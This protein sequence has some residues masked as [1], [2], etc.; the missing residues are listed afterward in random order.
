MDSFYTS[1]DNMNHLSDSSY[2]SV[3]PAD[4]ASLSPE[5]MAR[6]CAMIKPTNTGVAYLGHQYGASIPRYTDEYASSMSSGRATVS[7]EQL[8]YDYTPSP[9]EEPLFSQQAWQ[10]TVPVP[11]SHHGASQVASNAPVAHGPW[12]TSMNHTSNGLAPHVSPMSSGRTTI[13]PKELALDYT[14]EPDEKSLFPKQQ[15][16][17]QQTVPTRP[18]RQGDFQVASNAPAAHSSWPTHTSPAPTQEDS[19]APTATE[20]RTLPFTCTYSGCPQRFATEENLRDHKKRD[21]RQPHGSG[22]NEASLSQNGPH[23][24]EDEHPT[25][26]KPCNQTFSRPYDL[27]RH[28]RTVHQHHERVRCELCNQLVSRNDA[29]NRHRAQKHPDKFPDLAAKTVKKRKTGHNG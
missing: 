27:T 22:A 17:W 24:C 29:M 6:L 8:S 21:H 3:G 25:T 12:P 13:S 14:P 18:S 20:R 5:S 23:R 2:L 26:G 19:V 9:N 10:P 11:P 7:P 15:Q 4:L 16:R 28:Q 1:S